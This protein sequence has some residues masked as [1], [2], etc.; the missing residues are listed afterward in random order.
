MADGKKHGTLAS[1]KDGLVVATS[2]SYRE[3][4][5]TL[6]VGMCNSKIA[7]FTSKLGK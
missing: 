2:L 4:D 6:I 1:S 3:S 5:D 7:L